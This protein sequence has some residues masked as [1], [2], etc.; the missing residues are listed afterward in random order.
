MNTMIKN[1]ASR[2]ISPR[3]VLLDRSL[4]RPRSFGVYKLPNSGV[5]TR[6]FRLGNYPVRLYELEREFGS[7]ELIYLFRERNDA[8]AMASALNEQEL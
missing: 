2:S 3:D 8:V 4:T 6:L 7:C 5:S 1:I